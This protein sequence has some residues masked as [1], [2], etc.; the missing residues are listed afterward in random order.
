MVGRRPSDI[1]EERW[2]RGS[3]L[4]YRVSW[5]GLTHRSC[6]LHTAVDL[7]CDRS[8]RA[9]GGMRNSYRM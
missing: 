7:N 8:S 6:S 1:P 9:V 5:R 3:N 4:Y 2:G